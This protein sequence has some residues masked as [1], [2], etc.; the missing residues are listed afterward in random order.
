MGAMVDALSRRHGCPVVYFQGAIGGLMGTPKKLVDAAKAGQ[1]PSDT[2][3]FIEACGEAI[4]DLADRALA[5]AEPIK[6]EPLAIFARPISIPLDNDGFRAALAAGV[7]H[8]PIY[9]WT[10]NANVRGREAQ[11]G[12]DRRLALETEVAYLRLGEL[13]VAAIP[14]ELYP[15]CVYGQYQ[16]PVDPGADF[17]D[18]PLEPPIARILP[19][20]KFL[21]LGL[22]NDEVGYIVPKRQW[23][24]VEPFAYGRKDSQYGERNSVG[25]DTAHHLLTALQDRVADAGKPTVQGE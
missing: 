25:P 4:A 16:D 19:S 2:F 24:V 5:A 6:L 1:L 10:G 7:L 9:D 20:K 13:D 11:A 21:V 18:A 23:D 14:G 3:G 8:R 15:E 17:L 12:T 22:A